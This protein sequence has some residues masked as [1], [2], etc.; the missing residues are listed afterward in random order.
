[1][2]RRSLFAFVALVAVPEPAEPG[3]PAPLTTP[4]MRAE[5]QN[6]VAP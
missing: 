5:L 1:M 2:K 4:R 6:V 3:T